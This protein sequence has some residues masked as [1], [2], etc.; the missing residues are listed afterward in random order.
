LPIKLVFWV[1]LGSMPGY[2][3]GSSRLRPEG[4]FARGIASWAGFRCAL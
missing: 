3:V 4:L 2:V 1:E